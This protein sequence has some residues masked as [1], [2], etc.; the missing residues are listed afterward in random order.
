LPTIDEVPA[1]F[2]AGILW[3]FRLASLGSQLL[4]WTT[5][6]VLF[7]RWAAATLEQDR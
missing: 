5:I 3:N 4:L 7:G 6:G 1:D 2:P